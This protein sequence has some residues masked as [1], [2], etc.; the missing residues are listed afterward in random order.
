MLANLT[1]KARLFLLIALMSFIMMTLT[2]LNLYA[3]HQTNQSLQTVYTDRTVPLVA[4]AEIK[5]KLLHAR[6]AIVTGFPF[7]QEMFEQHKKVEQDI[8][9]INTLWREYSVTRLA[10]EEQALADKFSA[11]NRRFLADVKTA[12]QLQ[13]ADPKEDKEDAKSF[14]FKTVRDS[15]K[16]VSEGIN[17]LLKLQKDAVK[18][19]YENAQGRYQSTLIIAVA[20]LVSGVSLSLFI[21]LVIVRRLLNELGGEPNYAASVVKEIANGDLSAN[22]ELRPNDKSSLLYSIDSMRKTLSNVITSTNIVMADAAK[23]DLSSRMRVEVRGDFI[24]LKDGINMSLDTINSTLN[25]VM[26][27]AEALAKG[28]LSQ[29][30]TA[31]YHGVFEQTKQ[32]VNN[33]VEALSKI[34]EEIENI[35]YS[36]ADCGDFSIKMALHDKV[37]YGKR[38]ADLIN[39]LFST[40]ERSL[41]DVLRVAEALADGDL[42][43]TITNDYPGSFGAVKAGINTTV[44][45]LKDLLGEIKNTSDMIATAANEISSGNND[46]SHRTEEQAASLQQTAAS[47]DELSTTVQRNTDNAK[48]ANALALGASTTAKKGVEVV[49]TVVEN[50]SVINESSRHI[51]DIITVIDSIAFQTNILAL[52][53]AVEAARAGEQGKGFAV[54]AVE[55]RNLAQRSASAAGEIKRL[56]GDSVENIAEGSK[57]VEQAGKTMEEI[58]RAIQSVTNIMTEIAAASVQQN[59]GIGQVHQAITQMDT[60]TQQNAALVEQAAATTELLNEQTCNLTSGMAHFKTG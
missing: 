22:V 1:V 7:P 34:I 33:T 15:Y 39:Q 45:N 46:L 25:D 36:G 44:D 13:R 5:T 11:D 3:L 42:T 24:Q 53:A 49:N 51:V 38:L 57:Q 54:V 19:E 27:V 35:V 31:E 55:V 58:V 20:A 12:V 32:S 9:D 47:M 10:P 56:I 50:M 8:I 23:G 59:A 16:P 6:T 17:A 40:S 2:G 60:V 14:Y 18:Q 21:G 29:H 30:I 37:G 26:R 48:H 43:Q 28:D 4:L 52:N 41:N